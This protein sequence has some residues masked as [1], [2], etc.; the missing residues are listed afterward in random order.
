MTTFSVE[1]SRGSVY[2]S[3]KPDTNPTVFARYLRDLC[4]IVTPVDKC[5]ADATLKDCVCDDVPDIGSVLV[6]CIEQLRA[7]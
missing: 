5:Y 2:A 4:E 1:V 7:F 6:F 3:T